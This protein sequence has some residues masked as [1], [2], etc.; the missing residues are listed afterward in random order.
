MA[1]GCLYC[2]L[3]LPDTTEFCPL[4]GRLIEKGF[5]IRQI[6]MS[7]FDRLREEMKGEDDFVQHSGPLTH[8]EEY[9]HT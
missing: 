7:K 4:C 2:G 3:Q 9:A 1:T 5:E 8:M 6:Q